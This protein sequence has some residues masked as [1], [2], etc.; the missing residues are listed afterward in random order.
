MS[1]STPYAK[2]GKFGHPPVI[3]IYS[4][5]V[6]QMMKTIK[7]RIEPN[8]EQRRIIDQMIDANRIVYNNMLTACKIHYG[9][10]K[11]Y[12]QYSI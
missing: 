4:T 6:E 1:G 12:Q 9:N 10:T 5:I 8:S 2:F 11:K 3:F 7:F